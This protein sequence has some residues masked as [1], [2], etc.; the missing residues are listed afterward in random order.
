MEYQELKQLCID[1]EHFE[2]PLWTVDRI[3]EKEIL[4][5]DV[6]DPCTGTGIMAKA[7]SQRGYNVFP[8]DIHDWGYPGTSII[9]FLSAQ[10]DLCNNIGE[11][12]IFMNPPFS[13]TCEFLE[14][15]FE[16]GARKVVM[17]QRWAFKE[18]AG[19]RE[20]LEKY[21]MARMYLCGD[22]ASSYRHDIPINEKGKRYNPETMKEMSGTST[23]HGYFVWE[24]GQEQSNPP[25]F[26]L[27][28]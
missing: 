10:P 26:M 16:L 21:P 7:A 27:Y 14:K 22:R 4:T 8:M 28:K 25:T 6:I 17:F 3:L 23:A 24:K 18:S 19:R 1:L 13:K 9:D 2:T 11:F 12:T 15:A 20:F 5:S